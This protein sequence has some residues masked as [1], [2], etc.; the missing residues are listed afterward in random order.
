MVILLRE[1]R[2]EQPNEKRTTMSVTID[3]TNF[4]AVRE[5]LV[6]YEKTLDRVANN[7]L[8]LANSISR[9]VRNDTMENLL[10]ICLDDGLNIVKTVNVHRGTASSC[11]VSLAEIVRTAL[12]CK[13]A[14]RFAIVHNHPTGD[15]TP[16]PADVK[17]TKALTK[18]GNLLDLPLMDSI[19]VGKKVRYTSLRDLGLLR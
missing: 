6:A 9:K 13:N 10:V 8:L 18:A 3:K 17:L 15:T 19:I 12:L 11:T 2:D 4:T 5:A 14:T 7:S 16:S 1:K